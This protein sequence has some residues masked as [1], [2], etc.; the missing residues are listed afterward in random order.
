MTPYFLLGLCNTTYDFL[1]TGHYHLDQSF[2]YLAAKTYYFGV[3]GGTREFESLLEEKGI[4]QREIVKEFTEGNNAI[5]KTFN[6]YA[7]GNGMIVHISFSFSF[8]KYG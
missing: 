1:S 7:A 2:R 8:T 3:G 6:L 4:F 5:F